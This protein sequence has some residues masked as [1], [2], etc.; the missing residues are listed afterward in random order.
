[1]HSKN[2]RQNTAHNKSTKAPA[3]FPLTNV[4]MAATTR[5]NIVMPYRTLMIFG[6]INLSNPNMRQI[7]YRESRSTTL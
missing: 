2:I 6:V 4:I 3:A 7:P 5:S 1:M